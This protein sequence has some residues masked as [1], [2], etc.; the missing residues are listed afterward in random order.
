MNKV[1]FSVLFCLS[2]LLPSLGVMARECTVTKIIDGNTIQI[3]TGETVRY[4]GAATPKLEGKD[5]N[6][7]F[8]AKEAKKYNQK[9]VFMKKIQLE[10][11]KEQKDGD[12]NLLAYVFVKKT[13]VN[14][15]LVKL[16]YARAETTGPNNKYKSTF[17]EYEKKAAKEEKGLWQEAKRDTESSYIGN[18]RTYALH[19]P[20]CKLAD[21]I[22]EKNR[23]IFRNR[24]DAL[25]IGYIP[26]KVCKP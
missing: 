15:E 24:T 4:I 22:P 20:S 25:K 10:L 17:A 7:E 23:I 12:G 6:P 13:F 5:G 19:R 3:D 2:L 26:C 18:K 21:K 8:F 14:G 1:I 9:L 11:D 16:G